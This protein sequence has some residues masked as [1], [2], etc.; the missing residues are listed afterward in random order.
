[1]NNKWKITSIFL[2]GLFLFFIDRIAKSFIFINKD[3]SFS[4]ANGYFGLDYM[5]NTGIAFGMPFNFWLLIFF[6]IVI[7]IALL[8]LA[9]KK[10]SEGEFAYFASLF[11]IIIGAFSNLLD[12]IR[13]GHVIDYLYL[14]NFS[15]FNLADAMITLGAVSFILLNYIKQRKK[16]NAI[17]S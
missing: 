2:A 9:I 14:K 12:R 16:K 8:Y 15:V 6:Y 1:M 7:I 13:F 4:F 17:N 3:F 10:V 5:E 11:F